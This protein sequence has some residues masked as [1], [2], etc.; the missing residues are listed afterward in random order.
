MHAGAVKWFREDKHFGFITQQ[1]G[2]DIFFHNSGITGDVEKIMQEN[3]PV[4]YEVISTD[5]GPQ[6]VNV[7]LRE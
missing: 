2:S 6:A 5:R 1:D 7:H 4:W 3:A